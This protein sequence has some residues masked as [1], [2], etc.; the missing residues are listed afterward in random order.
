M[1]CRYYFSVVKYSKLII[2]C[3]VQS[4]NAF[5]LCFVLEMLATKLCVIAV[6]ANF[7]GL[8]RSKAKYDDLW[9]FPRMGWM[10]SGFI[11]G[12]KFADL[13]IGHKHNILYIVDFLGK[14]K[15]QKKNDRSWSDRW[16]SYVQDKILWNNL[17]IINVRLRKHSETLAIADL[18]R[19]CLTCISVQKHVFLHVAVLHNWR[20]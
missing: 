7:P 18:Y 13:A 16:L 3:T 12:P 20:R 8:C 5:V 10:V 1:C 14:N 9:L 11:F 6:S 4:K 15:S 2:F 19:E 17:K